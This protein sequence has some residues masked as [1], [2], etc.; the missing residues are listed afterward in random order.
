MHL[1]FSQETRNLAR[2]IV[3]AAPGYAAWRAAHGG[4][5]DLTKA[6][7]IEGAQALG[8]LP[9]IEKLVRMQNRKREK[10]LAMPHGSNGA[11]A[12]TPPP[13]VPGAVG[14]ALADMT[15]AMDLLSETFAVVTRLVAAL[16]KTEP[17]A[18]EKTS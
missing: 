13:F 2:A 1:V 12:P 18:D 17:P 11:A 15:T 8:V 3:R 6:L 14:R 9:A 5:H 4:G 7:L 16:S 10:L